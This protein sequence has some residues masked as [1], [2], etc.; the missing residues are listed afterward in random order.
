MVGL[1]ALLGLTFVVLMI[2]G[3]VINLVCVVDLG[4][5]YEFCPDWWV[6]VGFEFVDYY[7]CFELLLWFMLF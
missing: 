1:L 5:V 6:L 2:V 7:D 4:L 3:L